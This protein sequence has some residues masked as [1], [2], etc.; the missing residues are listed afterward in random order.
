MF[1]CKNLISFFW[2]WDYFDV[3]TRRVDNCIVQLYSSGFAVRKS[4]KISLLIAKLVELTV[5]IMPSFILRTN[6][7]LL[8][9]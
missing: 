5:S 9:K 7:I 2:I 6:I 4:I 3:V 8:F 1:V